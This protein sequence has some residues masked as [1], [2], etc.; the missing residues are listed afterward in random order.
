MSE[1]NVEMVKRAYAALNAGDIPAVLGL[2]HP[3]VVFDNTN[4]VFDASVYQGYEG[5]VEFFS[6]GREMWES[7]RYEPEEFVPLGDDRVV[8]PQRIVSVGR[9]GVETIARNTNVYTLIDGKASNIKSFQT[10]A[11]AL[12]AAGLSD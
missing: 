11:E 10:K 9:D 5:L 12:E 4:A 7:Q 1:E 6:L 2:C 8:V 3:D